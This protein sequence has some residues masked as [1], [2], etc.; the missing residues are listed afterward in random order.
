MANKN[1]TQGEYNATK[2]SR[3]LLDAKGENRTAAEFCDICGIGVSTFSRY[4]NGLK[5]RSCPVELLEK[6]AAHA[7]PESKVTLELLLAANGTE[8]PAEEVTTPE[9]NLNEVI[10]IL[11]TTLLMN[12]Y[13][14]QYPDDVKPVDIMGLPYSPSWTINTTAIDGHSLKKWDFILWKVYTDPSSETDRFIRQLLMILGIVHLGCVKLD[15]LSFVF[16]STSLYEKVLERTK[17][18]KLDFCLS[19]LLI[20]PAA[21]QISR[22]DYIAS[23][24]GIAPTSIMTSKKDFFSSDMSLLTSENHNLL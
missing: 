14:C 18:I 19:L 4:A 22:E 17:N 1:I 13:Q 9:L 23:T 11:T 6:V 16:S 21:K 8:V 20:D 24:K 7:A 3:L 10:G 12:Q 5:K 15:K 2:M